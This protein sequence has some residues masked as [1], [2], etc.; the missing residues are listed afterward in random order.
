MILNG[1]DLMPGKKNG[2]FENGPSPVLRCSSL[3]V[4][5]QVAR[6]GR[7]TKRDYAV[8]DRRASAMESPQLQLSLEPG[9]SDPQSVSDSLGNNSRV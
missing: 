4:K 8:N 7:L 5:C 1:A 3:A 6:L 9:A 2:T